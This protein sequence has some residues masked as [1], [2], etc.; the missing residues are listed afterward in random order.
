MPRPVVVVAHPADPTVRAIYAQELRPRANLQFLDALGGS[1]RVAR[2]RDAQVLVTFFPEQ[3]LGAQELQAVTRT[4]FIQCLAAGRDRFPFELFST[5]AV[6]FNPGAAAGP[7]AEHAVA[8][9]LA[10]AKNLLPR[11]Q[12]L[13]RGE[14]N[15]SAIN[16]R[17]AGGTA[18]VLGLGAIG[19]RV[20]RLLQAFGMKVRGINRT[21]RTEHPVDMCVAMEHFDAA[22]EQ[23]DVLVVAAELNAQTQDAI[24][25]K[26]LRLLQPD[27]ILV[28][29]SRAGLVQQA[30][31]FS[32]LK[33]HPGFRACLDVWWIEPMHAGKFALEYPFFD[34]PNVLGSPHNAP[35][36]AGIFGDL[37]RAASR[38]ITR[39]LDGQT[40]LHLASSRL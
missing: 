14:F 39:F 15:Q 33:A 9:V 29:V 1:E 18:V 7:I 23:A 26:Q 36:V 5:G 19:S 21:G 22:L 38:N 13:V 3:E 6:S 31:L 30:C 17:L 20:A 34:M 25:E 27:A 28:N 37:A 4:P 24:G 35:M 40:P 16:T 10:A 2:L 8:M 32:H 12:Q 11:H